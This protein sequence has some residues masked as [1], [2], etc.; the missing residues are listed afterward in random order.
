MNKNTSVYQPHILGKQAEQGA[1]EYLKKQGLRLVTQNFRCH[2]GEIDLIMRDGKTLV[3]IEVRLR[4]NLSRGSG[5]ESI[6][7]HKQRKIMKTA[8]FYLLIHQLTYKIPCRFDVVS[9][10]LKNGTAEFSW[11]KNAFGEENDRFCD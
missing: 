2:S 11:I 8:E 9:V 7:E 6:T 4:T 3:F 1:C 5:L 10:S